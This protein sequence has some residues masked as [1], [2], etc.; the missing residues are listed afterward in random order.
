MGRNPW[1]L[2]PVRSIYNRWRERRR[3][4]A[5]R[6]LEELKVRYHTFR[7][8]LTHNEIS[9]DLLRSVDRFLS[10][11]VPSRADL[12]EEIDE[13][14]D[15]TYELVDGL[16]RL[17][18]DRY[19][20]LYEKH[21]RIAEAVRKKLDSMVSLP[22]HVFR[23]FSL[24]NLTGDHRSL[25]GGK[26]ATLGF[27]RTAGFPVPDGF[28]VTVE[29]CAEILT[30]NGLDVYIARRLKRLEN[31]N[32]KEA[33]LE[34]EARDIRD[35]ILDASF[36]EGLEKD[37]LAAYE[38]LAAEEH[39]AVSLRSSAIVE[40]Q[41]E[42]SFA[43]QFESVLNV[44]TFNALESALKEVL[45]SNYSARAVSY[46]LHAGLPLSG[47]DMAV[48]CQLMI[49][50]KAAGVLFTVDPA[51]PESGRVLISAVPGLGI[52]A[53]DGSVPTDLYRPRRDFPDREPREEWTRIAAK[54]HRATALVEGGIRVEEVSPDER[55]TPVLSGEEIFSLVRHGRMIENLIGRPQDIEWALSSKGELFILQSRDIRLAARDRHVLS[56]SRGKI[57][58]KGGV[59]AS[60]GR[61]AGK[62]KIIHSM[63]DVEAWRNG[64]R[65]PGIMVL[66]RSMVDAAAW[67]PE[68]EGVIVD[69]GNPA[70]HLSCV[71]REYSRPMLTGTGRATEVLQ[72]GEWVILDADSGLILQAPEDVW[73]AGAARET[74][75]AGKKD[76]PLKKGITTPE[77]AG[78]RELIEPLNLTDAYGPTFSIRECK[79]LHDIIR[80]THEMAVLS[81]FDTGDSVMEEAEVLLHRLDEGLPFHF[82]IIDLGGGIAPDKNS[83]KVHLAD[84]QSIPLLALWKGMAT[85][86]LRW[87]LPPPVS[88]LSGLFSKAMLDARSSRPVGN[89]NYAFITRDYLN[90]NARVDFHFT[91]VDAVCGSNA[92]ENYIRFR[93]KG[94]GT[95]VVQR[96]RR[97]RFV[98]EV[99]GE[100]RFFADQQGDLVNASIGET[101]K[102]EIEERLIMIGR[103]LGFSRLLDA[104]MRDDSVPRKVARAFLDGD[105]GLESMSEESI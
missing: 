45:A 51:A 43:G 39:A 79:S 52:L 14:L 31:G 28:A 72:D 67:L 63:Q 27:L 60:P 8:L 97:A 22:A 102:E 59:I 66:H 9:L 105:Y 5:T 19:G 1:M 88:G 20:A 96:E 68:F 99:L 30:Q 25:V 61:C 2:N 57:L 47:H 103:L 70:D 48:L 86:G 41:P 100:H 53:V 32:V 34:A 33:E 77:A 91:M 90:L 69:L 64:E 42:H 21:R 82:L 54:T 12:S 15:V 40:D 35:N 87:S 92:R 95:T 89:Q 46:R 56:E 26:A 101:Q 80:Y 81:M 75:G 78:L 7:I 58:L 17:T 6:V 62:A 4:R 73:S 11:P 44:T 104:T 65:A 94:G 3:A 13:L 85:P 83:F 55:D 29:G 23:C 16:N 76:L 49:P 71:A 74:L 10:S 18:G 24:D 98:A 84:I 50:A 37:L 38:R 93:F 36:P